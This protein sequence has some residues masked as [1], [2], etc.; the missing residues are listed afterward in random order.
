MRVQP[1]QGLRRASRIRLHA[2]RR[3]HVLLCEEIDG[4]YNSRKF[5]PQEYP[6]PIINGGAVMSRKTMPIPFSRSCSRR[7]AGQS[8]A[9]MITMFFFVTP[10]AAT[11]ADL[12]APHAHA[13]AGSSADSQQN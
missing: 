1:R 10:I 9:L 5:F 11:R 7:A 4:R 2:E 8:F 12:L 3:A 6:L 13:A